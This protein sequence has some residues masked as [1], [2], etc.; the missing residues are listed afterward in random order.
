MNRNTLAMIERLRGAGI[1]YR[2]ALALRRI[3]MT[4][5]RWHELECGT[6]NGQT[7]YSIERDGPEPGD[8]PYMRMQYPTKDGYV[9]R[10]WRIADRELGAHRRLYNLMRRYPTLRAYVQ[11]DP[12]G[13]ALHILRR[14]DVP[15][16]ADV[17]AY[18]DRG[19][20]VFK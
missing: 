16:G 15:D 19:I 7:T 18:Y 14:D 20:A 12:R 4:L 5:Q 8:K 10:R 3:S 13:A 2:D 6:G 1:S 11:K 9:D 17:S